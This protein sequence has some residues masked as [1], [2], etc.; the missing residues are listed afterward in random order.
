RLSIY[1]GNVVITDTNTTTNGPTLSSS[2]S[3]SSSTITNIDSSIILSM[4]PELFKLVDEHKK[5]CQRQIVKGIDRRLILLNEYVDTLAKYAIDL[6]D[7][8]QKAFELTEQADQIL[9]ELEKCIL[10][11]IELTKRI[12]LLQT[13]V[14]QLDYNSFFGVIDWTENLNIKMESI[15]LKRIEEVID[16]WRMT[17][18][19]N[20]TLNSSTNDIKE[21]K[22]ENPF[23]R[24]AAIIHNI[25]M[26][27]NQQIEIEPPMSEAKMLL[28]Q[29]LQ[30]WLAM[31][32]SLKHPR[33]DSDQSEEELTIV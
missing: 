14:P 32:V 33:S 22:K 11:L 13:I 3:L 4:M 25:K 24:N 30:T 20:W 1:D 7:R 10:I 16:G 27:P 8:T 5:L 6:Q 21:L 2:S 15:L 29:D 19:I 17:L 9:L 18:D 28:G 12:E 23:W 26:T 31:I